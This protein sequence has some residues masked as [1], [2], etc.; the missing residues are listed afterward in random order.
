MK[1]DNLDIEKVRALHQAGQLGQAEAGYLAILRKNPRNVDALHALGILYTQQKNFAD[2][3]KYLQAAVKYQPGNSILQLHLANVLKAQGLF[4]QAAAILQK[5]LADNPHYV[6]ALNNLGTVFYAQGK[7]SEAIKVYRSAIQQEPLFIDAYYNL[8]LALNKQNFL[9][10]AVTT[11]RKLL[12]L[13]PEHFAARFHLACI[14]MKQDKI[15]DAL[16][17]LTEVAKSQPY[18]FETQS[19]IA[20]CYLKKGELNSAKIHYLQALEFMPNDVQILFNLGIINTQQGNVDSAIQFYQKA[21][22]HNPDFFA[23][24]NNLGVAFL[25]KQHTAFALHH[26]QEAARLQPD[27]SSIQYTIQALSQNQPVLSAPTDYVKSLFDAYADHYEQHLLTALDYQLPAHLQRIIA[28]AHPAQASWDILDLGCGTGLC[29]MVVKPFAKT[30]AGV[31]L[32]EKMLEAAAAKK[33]YDTLQCDELNVFLASR[34]AE[35][36]L[37][38]AGDVLVYMGDLSALFQHIQHALRINGLFA[39]NTEISE[40]E[41]YKMNQ[42]GRFSHSKKYLDELAKKNHLSIFHYEK[43]ITRMQNNEPVY[44]HL[45]IFQHHPRK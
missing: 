12:E 5:T 29:G 24:H 42:S 21:V 14:L 15:D 18:H 37:I 13:A 20:V 4:E 16:V 6:S 19:N 26:F 3:I 25:A 35:Y 34:H 45:Y 28:A 2:A 30:L 23:A 11:Y 40:N 8:G 36:D 7:L 33:I 22:R 17:E 39:F 31:D 32:S 10:E 1:K 44:G 38:L 41:D 43:A 27:N 9:D